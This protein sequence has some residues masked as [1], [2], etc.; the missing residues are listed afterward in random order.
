MFTGGSNHFSGYN[1]S[2]SGGGYNQP[3]PGAYYPN[4]SSGNSGGSATDWWGN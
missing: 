3:A 1:N 2:Y 4:N